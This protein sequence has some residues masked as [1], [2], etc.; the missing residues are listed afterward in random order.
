MLGDS[1]VEDCCTWFIVFG[2]LLCMMVI[3]FD[4]ILLWEEQRER[5]GQWKEDSE[6]KLRRRFSQNQP[7]ASHL[8][9]ACSSINS[10]R[11]PRN[12]RVMRYFKEFKSPRFKSSTLILFKLGSVPVRLLLWRKRRRP[13]NVA[14]LWRT[15]SSKHISFWMRSGHPS[16]VDEA[17]EDQSRKESMWEFARERF[18]CWHRCF[19]NK[20]VA[21]RKLEAW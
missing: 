18:A 19:F 4:R 9:A 14:S 5:K 3:L 6:E 17:P 13:V 1:W 20:L 7:R 2:F 11:R 12:T 21:K 15:R 8:S 16:S 10:R